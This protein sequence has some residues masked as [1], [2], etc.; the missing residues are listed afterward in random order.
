MALLE[1][2]DEFHLTNGAKSFDTLILLHPRFPAGKFTHRRV[3]IGMN[4]P[5]HSLP[6][7]IGSDLDLVCVS[8]RLANIIPSR[9]SAAIAPKSLQPFSR[10][11]NSG[12]KGNRASCRYAVDASGLELLWAVGK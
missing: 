12:V 11:G 1:R 3:S 8:I 10:D 2:N 5:S 7:L 9:T 4:D 6:Q